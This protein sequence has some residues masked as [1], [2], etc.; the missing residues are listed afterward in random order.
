[1]VTTLPGL[2]Y[3]IGTSSSKSGDTLSSPGTCD[4]WSVLLTDGTLPFLGVKQILALGGLLE[5][6]LLTPLA[7]VL[8]LSLL[9]LL[10]ALFYYPYQND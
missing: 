2:R 5:S 1:M 4:S 8:L 9:W 10:L 7:W 3:L 6:L